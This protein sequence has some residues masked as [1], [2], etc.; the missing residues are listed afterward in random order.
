MPKDSKLPANIEELLQHAINADRLSVELRD[1]IKALNDGVMSAKAA[2]QGRG[3]SGLSVF[4]GIQKVH[5]RHMLGTVLNRLGT[6]TNIGF[7][8]Y[9]GLL[10]G[11][12]PSL[13]SS[14]PVTAPPPPPPSA[15]S[16]A[17]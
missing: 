5:A 13:T 7:V 10:R 1:T 11:W 9:Q 2:N 14:P 3:P 8:S 12:I 16:K 6:N 17:A 15:A 4:S